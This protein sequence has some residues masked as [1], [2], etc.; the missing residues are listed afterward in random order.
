MTVVVGLAAAQVSVRTW[1]LIVVTD[2][3]RALLLVWEMGV[4]ISNAYVAARQS[5]AVAD[6]AMEPVVTVHEARNLSRTG[7]LAPTTGLVFS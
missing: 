1:A 4:V 7:R 2:F 6:T 5:V 3:L